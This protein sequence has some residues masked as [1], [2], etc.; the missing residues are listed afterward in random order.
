MI[1][2]IILNPDP[3]LKPCVIHY[4]EDHEDFF[5]DIPDGISLYDLMRLV[6]E[7]KRITQFE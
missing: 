6:D 4:K 1:S 5:I 3:D 7:I 2:K